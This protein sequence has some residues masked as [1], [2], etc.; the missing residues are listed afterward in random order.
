MRPSHKATLVPRLR[1]LRACV[2]LRGVD[3]QR[4]RDFWTGSQDLKTRGS[5]NVIAHRRRCSCSRRSVLHQGRFRRLKVILYNATSSGVFIRSA[6][7]T[8]SEVVEGNCFTRP[9]ERGFVSTSVTRC[10]VRK[11][12]AGVKLFCLQRKWDT[13]GATPATLS[14]FTARTRLKAHKRGQRVPTHTG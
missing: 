11:S 14:R 5:S 4:Q 7:S 2:S 1:I 10:G 13:A 12:S 3:G 6:I 9:S 8:A